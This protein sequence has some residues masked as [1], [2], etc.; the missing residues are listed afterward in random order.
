MNTSKINPFFSP[1]EQ[2]IVSNYTVKKYKQGKCS[3]GL[4]LHTVEDSGT[5]ASCGAKQ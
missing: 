3:C 4:T 1:K 5:C 2:D